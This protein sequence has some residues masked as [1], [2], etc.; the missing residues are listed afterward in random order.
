MKTIAFFLLMLLVKFSFAQK[1][2]TIAYSGIYM[3]S[4]DYKGNKL[5]YE[6]S[7]DSSSGKIRLNHFLSKNYI[8]VFKN[9]KK[10]Q[11][12][13][14]SIFGYRDCKQNDYRFYTERDKEYQIAE[15]KTIVI[16]VADVAVTSANGKARE[17][18]Q[19]YFFST[20]LN[21]T[22][23]PL[24]VTNL[25]KAFPDNLKF[26]NKLDLEF[27]S[28]NDISTFDDVHKMYKVNYLLSQSVKK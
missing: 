15:N 19:K 4:K 11:L 23:L 5:S 26:H 28:E 8:D 25:K 16:Y 20:T 17:F 10:I 6:V 13:K 3:N 24:T 1:S 14:D 21:S 12:F 18:V 7:C 27:S 22:I 9:E 2:D